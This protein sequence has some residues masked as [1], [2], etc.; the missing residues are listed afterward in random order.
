M[1]EWPEMDY[2][3]NP[4]PTNHWR[5]RKRGPLT[6]FRL[7]VAEITADWKALKELLQ[8]PQHYGKLLCCHRCGAE[9][10][11]GPLGFV[12]ILASALHRRPEHRRTHEQY[13]RAVAASRPSICGLPWFHLSMV[14]ADFMH[15]V[16]LGIAQLLNGN[17]LFHLCLE[18]RFG[19]T[20]IARADVRRGLQLRAAWLEFKA[21]CDTAG[22]L[23]SQHMFTRA[24]LSMKSDQDSPLLKAK[25]S[26]TMKI[27]LWLESIHPLSDPDDNPAL[28]TRGVAV[29]AM[30]RIWRKCKCGQ[31][32]FTKSQAR[33]FHRDVR[34]FLL[35]YR[36]LN[37]TA[38]FE[39]KRTWGMRPKFHQFDHIGYDA[40]RTLRN[41]G[42]HWAFSDESYVG[43]IRNV[44]PSMPNRHLTSKRVLQRHY[45]G[46]KLRLAGI[47]KFK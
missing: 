4:W 13:M 23:H 46:P 5:S 47:V 26:N 19:Y 24:S 2:D 31:R 45:L 18:G 16:C 36:M 38:G 41:P 14:L 27:V 33:L 22:V 40:M 34:R 6:S 30:A 35:A 44:V 1:N 11:L 9:R 8:L 3:G 17:V 43:V 20:T 28:Y 12:H 25:A 10:N 21:W 29:R 39:G 37:I 32:F 42:S 7:V 15:V